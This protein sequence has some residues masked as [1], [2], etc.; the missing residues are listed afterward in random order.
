VEDRLGGDDRLQRRVG[1]APD[2]AERI[3]DLLR[4]AS[5][6]ASYASLRLVREVLEAAAAALG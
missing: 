4:L 3:G 6:C 1:D 2:A 5:I